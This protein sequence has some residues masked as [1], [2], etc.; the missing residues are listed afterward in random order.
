MAATGVRIRGAT[1]GDRPQIAHLCATC[2]SGPLGSYEDMHTLHL[3]HTPARPGFRHENARVA[4][5]GERVVSHVQVVPFTIDYGQSRLTV[6]GIGD[7]CTDP[8]FRGQGHAAALMGDA[9]EHMASIG[10]DISL[11]NGIANYYNRFGYANVWPY[12]HLDVNPRDTEGLASPLTTRPL[13]PADAPAILALYNRAW[14]GR[15]GARVRDLEYLTWALGRETQKVAAV[16]A[17][18]RLR[19]YAVEWGLTGA[20]CEVD[21][22]DEAAT[23]ALLIASAASATAAYGSEDTQPFRWF[24]PP[25]APA[26]RFAR[27]L[28]AVELIERTRP[29]GGWMG[30]IIN[31]PRTI[32]KLLPELEARLRESPHAGW[33]GRLRLET[34]IGQVTLAASQG[35]LALGRHARTSL[36]ARMRQDDLIQLLFAYVT[37]AEVAARAH[38]AHQGRRGIDAEAY[39]LLKA[40]FPPRVSYIAGLDWF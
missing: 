12:R 10:C 17:A 6:G 28:C 15:P 40:L 19:G 2:F 36:V 32:E 25:D 14:Q 21:A 8:E 38:I 30:R 3:E 37:P 31:L 18:G 16:D 7:V 23:A 20:V 27:Q 1:A 4:V 5:L 11:L 39:S 24:I 13:T 26:A 29:N 33:T 35:R 34:D 22:D 9:L